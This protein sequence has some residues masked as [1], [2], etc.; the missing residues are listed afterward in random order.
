MNDDF[1]INWLRLNFTALF[2]CPQVLTGFMVTEK[3]LKFGLPLALVNLGLC[4]N[5]LA[6]SKRFLQSG[7]MNSAFWFEIW[8]SQ[9]EKALFTFHKVSGVTTPIV[10]VSF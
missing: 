10:P 5:V 2:F 4:Q 9:F 1:V 7:Q 8:N 3:I 6:Y